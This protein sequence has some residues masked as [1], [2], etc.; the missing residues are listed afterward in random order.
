MLKKLRREVIYLLVLRKIIPR[1]K[2]VN[3]VEDEIFPK[4]IAEHA[5]KTPKQ[6]A[7]YFEDEKVTYQQLI[8]RANQYSHWFLKNGLKR[9]DVVALLM[10]NR[11]E[12]LIVWIGITQIG[13]TVALIN[14]NLKGHPLDHSLSISSAKHI[15]IGEEMVNNFHSVNDVIRENL[16]V[17][18][19]GKKVSSDYN[20]LNDTVL[21]NSINFPNL[22]YEVTNNDVALYIYTSGTTGDPKAA[23]ISHKRLR[24]MPMTFIAA[25]SPKKSDKIYNVLPLY[26]SAGGVVA[27][28]IALTTG[29]SL[30]LR[31]KF[32]VKEFW[33][34]VDRYKVTIFQYIGELCRYLLNAPHNEYEK[35]HNL[36]IAAGNGLRPD[37]WDSFKKRFGIKKIV[38]FYGATEGTFSLI[39][40][41]GKTGA[42]GRIPNYMKST[43]NV[44]IVKFDIERGEPIRNKQGYCIL[45]EYGEPGEALGKIDLDVGGFDGYVDKQATE[46]K[47]LRNVFEE[48][49]QWFQSGDL[50]STDKD[51]YFYFIDRIGDTFRWKGENVATS[52]VAFA[53]SNIKGIKEANVYGVSIPGNDGKAGMA[54]LVIDE[55]IDLKDLYFDLS[56]SLPSYAVPLMLRIKK[57]IEVTGT[58]KHR[59]VELVR[60]GYDPSKV[61][62]PI[63]IIDNQNKT[64]IDLNDEKF[65]KIKNEKVKF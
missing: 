18:I 11:P 47:I 56:K 27:V 51:G 34:D 57:Q 30:V 62:D 42:I 64:Y 4:Q 43:M 52:E 5:K 25:I 37:I 39:N 40:F 31:R 20:N 54:A 45:C 3:E 24:L 46:K 26:H 14:T 32:S 17:W 9:G 6:V 48:G 63:Y 55:D 2:R 12:F 7:V 13:G 35:S 33:E 1:L 8:F 60:E 61:S 10:E 22:D 41:D 23:S 38:E 65:E 19:E 28:G 53:F 44:E 16:Q 59:K 36:R 21:N 50:L 15:I 29:A 58:F 49:D